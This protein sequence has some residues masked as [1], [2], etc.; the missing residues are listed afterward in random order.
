MSYHFYVNFSRKCYFDWIFLKVFLGDILY[1][2]AF[3]IIYTSQKIKGKNKIKQNKRAVKKKK[4]IVSP[5]EYFVFLCSAFMI[6]DGKLLTNAHCVEYNTQVISISKFFMQSS[7]FFTY[8]LLN[9][10][11]SL[12]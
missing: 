1:V 7:F 2:I 4:K 12:Y 10:I 5:N 9:I 3:Q 6:G 8:K 11:S